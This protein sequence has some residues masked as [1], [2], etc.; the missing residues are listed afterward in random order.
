L[1][2]AWISRTGPIAPSRSH[3][4][5]SE[6]QLR[7]RFDALDRNRD[8]MITADELPRPQLFKSMDGNGDGKITFE[9]ARAFYPSRG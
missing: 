6:R 9:E 2:Q 3:S 7:A 8:G 5:V 1:V 4:T